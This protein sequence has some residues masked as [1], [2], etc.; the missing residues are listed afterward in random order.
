MVKSSYTGDWKRNKKHGQGKLTNDNGIYEGAWADDVQCGEGKHVHV[1]GAQYTGQF[2]HGL[3]H[4]H[5]VCTGEDGVV[6]EGS[7]VRG[8]STP[9]TTKVVETPNPS[10]TTTTL[11]MVGLG[12]ACMVGFQMNQ[13]GHLGKPIKM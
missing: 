9:T 6:T 13:K 3:T 10:W 5:G 12:L 8:E 11:A 2:E 1:S 4:G 7:W